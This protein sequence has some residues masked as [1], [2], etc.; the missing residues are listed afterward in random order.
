MSKTKKATQKPFKNRIVDHGMADPRELLANPQNWRTHSDR[1]RNTL[2]GVLDE[3]GWVQQVIVNRTTGHI[4]DGHLRVD[5]AIRDGEEAVPVGF[6]EL[7]ESEE[8]L[9]LATFDPISGLA[10]ADPAIL[11][12]LLA[13]VQTQDAAVAQLI[14]ETAKSAGIAE[15]VTEPTARPGGAGGGPQDD[16]GKYEITFEDEDD[17]AAW[18]EFLKALRR[19]YQ[20]L[21]TIGERL[22]EYVRDLGLRSLQE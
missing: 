8:A 3:V 11:E 4:V 16:T 1:Q 15:Y 7:T 12:D 9:V 5:L 18:F 22:G 13:G 14:A 6:V 21:E 2:R 20:G 10:G 19:K 17:R